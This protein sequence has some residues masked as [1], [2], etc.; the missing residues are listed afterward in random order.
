MRNCLYAL[1]MRRK[2]QFYLFLIIIFTLDLSESVS[3]A[4]AQHFS[5]QLDTK[6]TSKDPSAKNTPTENS[7]LLT[8]EQVLEKHKDT[9][10]LEQAHHLKWA[11]MST[12]EFQVQFST[13]YKIPHFHKTHKIWVLERT[14]SPSKPIKAHFSEKKATKIQVVSCFDAITGK[15]VFNQSI[16]G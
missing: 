9:L 5:Q 11:L 13:K 12:Q 3:S 6:K 15:F 10:L 16:S 4:L 1:Q 2:K 8:K 7:T 14:Y